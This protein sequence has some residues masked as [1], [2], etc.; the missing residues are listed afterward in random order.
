MGHRRFGWAP[1]DS[2][3]VHE[4]F[5]AVMM[6]MA[7]NYN[8]SMLE[9]AVQTTEGGVPTRNRTRNAYVANERFT[10]E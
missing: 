6:N 5:A 7:S 2:L 9:A 8:V 3:T 4:F 10:I 1:F